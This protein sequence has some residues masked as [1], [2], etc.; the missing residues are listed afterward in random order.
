MKYG[1]ESSPYVRIK[2]GMFTMRPE[3]SQP[4]AY[5]DSSDLRLY[6]NYLARGAVA[7][8]EW[9]L[10]PFFPRSS[11]CKVLLQALALRPGADQRPV[12]H[13]LD[14]IGFDRVNLDLLH[15]DSALLWKDDRGSLH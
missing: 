4:L 5:C 3:T 13:H 2:S 14:L 10:H 1:L 11:G 12:G 7:S 6:F 9:V 8:V 15:C